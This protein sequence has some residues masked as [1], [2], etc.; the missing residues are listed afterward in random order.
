VGHLDPP[1]LFHLFFLSP[2]LVETHFPRGWV[3]PCFFF[4]DNLFF[5]VASCIFIFF[6]TTSPLVSVSPS[7]LVGFPQGPAWGPPPPPFQPL[8][9]NRRALFLGCFVC[10]ELFLILLSW[11]PVS[12]FFAAEVTFLPESFLLAGHPLVLAE[13][14]P[15][16]CAFSVF[17]FDCPLPMTPL[18][19]PQRTLPPFFTT[20][21]V[22]RGR[23][24]GSYPTHYVFFPSNFFGFFPFFLP[25]F[26]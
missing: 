1:T 22:H 21:L 3:S 6:R 10:F 7:S 15:L 14:A 5:S 24:K 23:R 26:S 4:H 12:F 19:S 20:P 8:C 18:F 11:A 9:E 2:P 25:C 13:V 17:F 16:L